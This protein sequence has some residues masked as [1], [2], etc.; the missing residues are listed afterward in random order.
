M[1]FDGLLFDKDGTLFDFQATWSGWFLNVLAQLS[2]GDLTKQKKLAEAIDFD[3]SEQAFFAHSVAIAGTNQDLVEAL[4]GELEGIS[5]KELE[6]FLTQ[7]S[8]KARVMEITP[9]VAFFDLLQL[10]GL[11]LGVRTNDAEAGARAHLDAVGVV[12]KLDFIAGYDSGFGAKPS[13]EPLLAFCASVGI[14]P[15]HVAMVGDSTHDLIAGKAAGMHCIGVLS[16]LA[17]QRTLQ[18]YADV[19]LPDISHIPSYLNLR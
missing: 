8:L 3:L 2:Q 12:Q 15:S 17:D 18:A 5:E 19:V 9:L 6:D 1:R 13:A 16:G 7:E 10:S 4:I 14:L 11:N